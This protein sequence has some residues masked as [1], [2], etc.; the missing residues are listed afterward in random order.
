MITTKQ[1]AFLRG[2]ANT[3]QPVTQIGKNGV[4]AAAAAAVDE[5]LGA[6][7]LIKLSVLDTCELTAREVCGELCEKCGAEPVQVI[8][9]KV[10][11]YRRNP[12]KPVYEIPQ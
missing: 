4:T 8:G 7:E 11:I 9:S 2:K 12:E 1:R 3:L 10:V 6:R 5:A